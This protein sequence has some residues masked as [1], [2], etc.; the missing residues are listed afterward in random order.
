MRALHHCR[1]L[2]VEDE[3]LVAMDM[4]MALGDAGCEVI[5]PVGSVAD[6]LAAV[7]T[8]KLDAAVLDVNLGD[9]PAFPVADALAAAG[10]PFVWLTGHSPEVIPSRHRH[11]PLLTKPYLGAKL[12]DAIQQAFP[13][14]QRACGA[15]CPQ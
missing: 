6:A 9:Q 10:I 15:L 14:E 5:G 8:Q 7:R 2:V 13:I 1:V 11:R 3:V 12:L 4:E